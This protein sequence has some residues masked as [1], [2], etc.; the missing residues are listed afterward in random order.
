LATA[1]IGLGLLVLL[2]LDTELS[3]IKHIYFYATAIM[4]VFLASSAALSIRFYRN[5]DL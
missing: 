5:R 2:N 4:M 3:G 1:V